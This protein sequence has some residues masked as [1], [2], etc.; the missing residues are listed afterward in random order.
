MKKA[1]IIL[2][3]M[4]VVFQSFIFFPLNYFV[5]EFGNLE[6][7][8]II[9]RILVF[10]LPIYFL[11]MFYTKY[12]VKNKWFF[13]IFYIISNL[14]AICINFLVINYFFQSGKTID[15]NI[16]NASNIIIY[17]FVFSAI[18]SIS[19]VLYKKIIEKINIL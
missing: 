18:Q 2:L 11:Q 19:S 5:A 14:V 15:S 1:I 6:M 13:I 12:Q 17:L 16:Y 3:L 7:F 8:E 9:I 10:L 4:F